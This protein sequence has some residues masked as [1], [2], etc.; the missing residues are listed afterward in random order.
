MV[1]PFNGRVS[2]LLLDQTTVRLKTARGLSVDTK[3]VQGQTAEVADTEGYR[4]SRA[5]RDPWNRETE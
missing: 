1:V 3:S 2:V 4:L 5:D